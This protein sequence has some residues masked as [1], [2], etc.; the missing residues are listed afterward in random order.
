M[1]LSILLKRYSLLLSTQSFPW[2]SCNMCFPN[3]FSW[4]G[5]LF[6]EVIDIPMD[7]VIRRS[8]IRLFAPSISFSSF[9][10]RTSCF[11][12][13]ERCLS[14]GNLLIISLISRLVS[15]SILRLSSNLP[16][17]FSCC[18][19]GRLS[20][21]CNISSILFVHLDTLHTTRQQINVGVTQG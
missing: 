16:M 21:L 2:L 1:S 19:Q 20:A 3:S 9:S 15:F 12:I 11:S 18:K 6:L 7:I 13:M 14:H 10:M 5:L 4:Y 17:S 8:S